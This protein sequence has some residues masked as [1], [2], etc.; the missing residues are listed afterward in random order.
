MSTAAT[1]A[2]LRVVI[3]VEVGAF[4]RNMRQVNQKLKK[5][6][7]IVNQ[8]TKRYLGLRLAMKVWRGVKFIAAQEMQLARLNS[9]LKATSNKTGIAASE[10]IKFAKALQ[11]A[12]IF[13]KTEILQAQTLAATFIDIRGIQF[14]DVIQGI[15]D[16]STTMGTGLRQAA[17]QLSKVLN[18]PVQLLGALRRSGVSFNKVQEDMI[19]GAWRA[20]EQIKAQTMILKILKEQGLDQNAQA[21][22]KTMGGALKGLM[23]D[24]GELTITFWNATGASEGLT[25]AFTAMS[26]WVQNL[27]DNLGGVDDFMQIWALNVIRSFDIVG[28]TMKS[29]FAEWGN[30]FGLLIDRNAARINALAGGLESTKEYFKSG[31]G[32]DQLEKRQAEQRQ[33]HLQKGANKL[34]EIERKYQEDVASIYAA[35]LAKTADRNEKII[36]SARGAAKAMKDL[37]KIGTAENK[38]KLAQEA[39]K[40]IAGSVISSVSAA[41][42][43][44]LMA[45]GKK[46]TRMFD[47]PE[48]IMIKT[49]RKGTTHN[50]PS[51]EFARISRNV[52]ETIDKTNWYLRNIAANTKTSPPLI[53]N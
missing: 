35:R 36:E 50:R 51:I 11:R 34:I 40:G 28:V 42:K 7:S 32:A 38:L 2:T 33:A 14:K 19:K 3:R 6:S 48:A 24:L 10:M 26:K 5:Q 23:N 45:S 20:G 8:L 31:G 9:V 17:L 1:L 29:M 41:P 4:N 52:L 27:E 16:L 37:F 39:I 46:R 43:D 30:E 53:V 47:S 15:L 12:T 13:T 25:Q 49:M 22:R 21:M 44:N 18:N